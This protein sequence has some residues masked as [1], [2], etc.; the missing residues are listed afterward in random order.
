MSNQKFI[1]EHTDKGSLH[2]IT[3]RNLI[4]REKVEIIQNLGGT[5]FQ[6]SLSNGSK[7]HDLLYSD[8]TEELRTNPLYRGRLLFPFNDRI[9]DGKYTFA[10]KEYQ[11]PINSEEDQ[12]AIH[13]LVYDQPFTLVDESL[14]KESCSVTLQFKIKADQFRGYPFEIQFQVK[15]ILSEHQLKLEFRIENIGYQVAPI[16]LGWHPYF[17][18]NESLQKVAL[19]SRSEHFV[20]VGANLLPTLN[21]LNCENTKYDFQES[22]EIGMEDYDIALTAPVDGVSTIMNR[23]ISILLTQDISFFKYLQLFTP[24]DRTSVAVEPISAATNAFNVHE[25]GM[26]TIAPGDSIRTDVSVGIVESGLS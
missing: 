2:F 8:S 24:E 20:E 18:F 15:Y 21:V 6:V 26:R 17:Q 4:N 13:G 10:G 11:L 14:N 19:K 9:P 25:L 5:V 7:L 22:K 12:S 23:D 1:V 16:A 3:L